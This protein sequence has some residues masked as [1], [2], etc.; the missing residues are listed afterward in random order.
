MITSP[1]LTQLAKRGVVF[2]FLFACLL[3]IFGFSYSVFAYSVENLANTPVSHDFVVGPG[4]IEL[5][6]KPGETKV[7]NLKVTNRMGDDREFTVGVE[8]FQGSRDPQQTVVLLGDSKGSYSLKNFILIPQRT[9]TL[10]HGQR[11]TVPVTISLPTN[12]DPGGLYGS[13]LFSI[14]S[15]PNTLEDSGGS[16][17]IIARIG[18][19]FFI[20]VPGDAKREGSLKDFSIPNDQTFFNSGPVK[21]EILFENKGNV[22]LD[23][24]GQISLRNIFGEEVGSQEIEPWFALPDSLRL[25][26]ISW[27]RDFLFGRYTAKVLIHRGY[28]ELSD[29]KSVSFWVVP[30]K[31]LVLVVLALFVFIFCVRWILSNFEFRRK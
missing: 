30:W 24:Y 14:V 5:S 21:F 29:V 28:N 1:F 2:F 12:A 15:K 4:K 9:F 23:P 16:S 27:N 3:S 17:A 22:H 26:E 6:L 20:T 18:T 7:V 8:D 19:L 10:Q 13:V 31:I 11:A 25:R